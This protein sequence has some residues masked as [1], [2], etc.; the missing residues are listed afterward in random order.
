[1][2]EIL[3]RVEAAAS[4]VVAA[5]L[6]FLTPFR[7]TARLFGRVSPPV[8]EAAPIDEQNLR[9]ALAATRRLKRVADRLPWT[10]TCLVRALAGRMLLARRGL[11]GGTVRFGVAKCDGRLSAHAWLVFGNVILIGGDT[12]TSFA[13]LADLAA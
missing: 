11:R 4:L 3:A 1:M 13:P 2:L 5:A 10:S 9:R 8:G 7:W 6:V 12:T